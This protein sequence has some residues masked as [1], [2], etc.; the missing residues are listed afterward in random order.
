KK[1][2]VYETTFPAKTNDDKAFVEDLWAR[3]KVGYLLDQIRA[4][5]EK[6]ELVNEVVSLAKKYGI[7]TPY[8]S[9]LI[10][11]DF[12][13][14]VAGPGRGGFQ[15]GMGG[16]M[17]GGSRGPLTLTS[18]AGADG[19]Y[20]SVTSF[21]RDAQKGPGLARNLSEL[22]GLRLDRELAM[23]AA[24]TGKQVRK[25]LEQAREKRQ[26]YAAAVKAFAGKDRDSFQ[27]GRLGVDLAVHSAGLR[28]QSRLEQ[29]AQRRVY[30]RTCLDFGGVW[31]D[32]KFDAK[33]PIVT[34]K[35]MS[36]AYFRILELRPKVKEVFQLGNYVV[37]VTPSGTALVIDTNEGKK[38]LSDTDIKK[39]FVARK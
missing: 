10:V 14:P 6:K 12:P 15:G 31:I 35:A 34:V 19:G 3:R 25:A 29:T 7:A 32:D 16:M 18:P 30:G 36:P 28:E 5:G 9:Y 1:E 21:A 39:L 22:E 4:N 8:T 2:Y 23:D 20:R 27:T 38:K 17:G 26:S 33:M 11:P 13:V 24:K 37:W